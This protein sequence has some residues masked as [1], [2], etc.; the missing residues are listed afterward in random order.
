MNPNATLRFRRAT[1]LLALVWALLALASAAALR[2]APPRLV[3]PLVISGLATSPWRIA[4]VS[5]EAA[6]AGVVPGDRLLAIDG[7]PV[8]RVFGDAER[9]RADATNRYRVRTRAGAEIEVALHPV[10]PQTIFRSSLALLLNVLPLIGVVY[11]AIGLLVWRARPDRAETWALFLFCCAMAA[12]LLFPA[13]PGHSPWLA[14]WLNLPLVGA[15][16][17]HLF[18]TY[19]IEPPWVV[20]HPAVRSLVYLLALPI[21]LLAASEG[22]LGLPVAVGRPAALWFTVLAFASS[23]AVALRERRRLR[24]TKAADRADVMVLGAVVS[25]LPSTLALLAENWLVA[26]FP[27]YLGFVSLFVFPLAV[28]Y[29]IVRRQLFEIRVVAKSSAA[30]G[31]STLAITGVYAFLITFA[32]AV[33]TRFNVNAHSPWFSIA[34]LFGAILAFNPLR[35]R[36]QALV[37]RVF[38][39]D[40]ALYRRAVREISEAMVSRSRGSGW[41]RPPPA[42]SGKRRRSASRCRSS[43]RCAG[44]CWPAATRS[45][46]ATSTTSPTSSC[47]RR[48]ATSSICSRSSWWCRSCSARSCSAR[49]ASATSIRASASPRRTA[50][51]C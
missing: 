43:T 45:S 18:T 27:G 42:A 24:E 25:F 33:V 26:P 16:T 1:A 9:F 50:S 7:R 29:G 12:Q 22:A 38:D 41:P 44:G 21:G 31:A 40:H 36:M 17:F 13:R 51:S 5:E 37:D 28:A 35:D 2:A 32:D 15:T 47:A 11:L 23:L 4:A 10:P 14:Y 49:S 34:F 20:R 48:A 3:P 6:G 30:Y 8:E 46:A 19:P 39:R